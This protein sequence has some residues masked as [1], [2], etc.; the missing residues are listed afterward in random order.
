MLGVSSI[1]Q[2]GLFFPE[3]FD[4]SPVSSYSPVQFTVEK[5]RECFI[6]YELVDNSFL[7]S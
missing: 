3:S 5:L 1:G 4:L 2:K 7:G 6:C